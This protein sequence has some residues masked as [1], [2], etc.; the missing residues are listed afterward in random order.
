MTET[1]QRAVRQDGLNQIPVTQPTNTQTTGSVTDKLKSYSGFILPPFRSLRLRSETP[2]NVPLYYGT[3]YKKMRDKLSRKEVAVVLRAY[4]FA[5]RAHGKQMRS[6]GIPYISHPMA[7]ANMVADMRLDVRAISAALLHDVIEDTGAS[8][9]DIKK[10]FGEEI[11]HLVE[12]LTKLRG[13]KKQLLRDRSMNPSQSANYQKLVLAMARDPRVILIKLSDRLHNLRTIHALSSER[14]RRIAKETML[15]YAPLAGRLGMEKLRMELEDLSFA[16]VYPMRYKILGGEVEKARHKKKSD[17]LEVIGQLRV[18]LKKKGISCHIYGRKKNLAG[19]YNK[20]TRRHSE[21]LTPGPAR[22]IGKESSTLHE[23]MDV[24][25]IRILVKKI[26]DCYAALGVLH[27]R[28]CPIAGRFKDYIAN[29]KKN[30][31]QSLHTTLVGPGGYPIEIQIRTRD[32]HLIAESGLA[33]HFLYKAGLFSKKKRGTEHADK[34]VGWLRGIA[35]SGGEGRELMRTLDREFSAREI[36]VYTPEG[37]IINLPAGACAVDFA[38]AVHTDMGAKCVACEID[39]KPASITQSLQTGQVVKIR[40]HADASPDFSWGSYAITPKALSHIAQYARMKESTDIRELGQKMLTDALRIYKP[41]ATPADIGEKDWQEYLKKHSFTTRDM[42]YEALCQG[43]LTPLT[44]AFYLLPSSSSDRSPNTKSKKPSLGVR[45]KNSAIKYA[46]CCHPI[47]GDLIVAM[48]MKQGGLYIHR[49]NCH[50]VDIKRR[51]LPAHWENEKEDIF[52][53]A[54]RCHTRNMPNAVSNIAGELARNKINVESIVTEN[55][56]AA[57]RV[58]VISL[59]VHNTAHLAEVI[60]KLNRVRD[61][62]AT[63]RIRG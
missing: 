8:H 29:P 22:Q 30:G 7:V 10:E 49:L 61:L 57:V 12:G 34:S 45:L 35:F 56:S 5:E 23:I 50:N 39:N 27:V 36:Y 11:A 21:W 26:D 53:V 41:N 62:T 28:M 40:T 15:V 31:Y 43:K 42:F 38:Y 52:P 55:D 14:Q 4:R 46:N 44:A 58:L 13:L 59:W 9:A 63:E 1:A 32:M 48:P 17:M 24:Y 19:I 2:T 6:S 16:A 47:P 25:G 54:I 60:H 20:M 33:A 18:Y 51:S 37:D 3:F